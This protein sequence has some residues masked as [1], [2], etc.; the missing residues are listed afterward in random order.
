MIYDQIFENIDFSKETLASNDFEDC[1]FSFCNFSDVNL[2]VLNSPI[3]NSMI[4]I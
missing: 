1:T 2:A 3:A 4:V